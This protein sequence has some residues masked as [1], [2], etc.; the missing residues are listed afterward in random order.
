M[1]RN[2]LPRILERVRKC[3]YCGGEVKGTALAFEENPFCSACLSD[4]L[5]K[6]RG[7]GALVSWTVQGEYLIPTD[8]G[9]Q[10]PQ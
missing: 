5:E 6:G 7:D 1:K 4:R 9:Q 2:T 10:K 3:A 8:L